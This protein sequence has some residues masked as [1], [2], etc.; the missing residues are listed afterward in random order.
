MYIQVDLHAHSILEVRE[1]GIETGKAA[2]KRVHECM[3]QRRGELRLHP[4]WSL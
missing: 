1:R 2:D 3:G 4:R